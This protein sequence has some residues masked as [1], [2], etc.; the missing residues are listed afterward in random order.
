VPALEPAVAPAMSCWPD[1]VRI[2]LRKALGSEMPNF[3]YMFVTNKRVHYLRKLD[4]HIQK[5]V[6]R[7]AELMATSAKTNRKSVKPM[8]F[9]KSSAIGIFNS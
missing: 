3:M 4:R 6:N 1:T 9:S 2:L 8:R 5:S 7:V